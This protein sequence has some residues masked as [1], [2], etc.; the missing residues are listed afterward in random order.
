MLS[1]HSCRLDPC[2]VLL[3]ENRS[4]DLNHTDNNK[5]VHKG[6]TNVLVSGHGQGKGAE[7][8]GKA[9]RSSVL[10]FKGTVSWCPRDA[11]GAGTGIEGC[12]RAQG[13]PDISPVTRQ[14]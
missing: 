12:P 3:R 7:G 13:P 14:T 11:S 1:V 4:E 9:G 6:F 10:P 2:G 8:G 5:P